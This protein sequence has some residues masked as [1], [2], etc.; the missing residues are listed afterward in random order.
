M[1]TSLLA[2]TSHNNSLTLSWP[3]EQSSKLLLALTSRAN[4]GF[5]PS[6]P[7]TIFLF[8]PDFYVLKWGL[9]FESGGA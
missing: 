9:L 1:F 4:L 7:T 2:G 5:G 6:G 3:T 8:F